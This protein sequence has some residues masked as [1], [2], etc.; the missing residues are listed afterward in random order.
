MQGFRFD[1]P[2]AA[3]EISKR[4]ETSAGAAPSQQPAALA[5]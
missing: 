1:R 4:I 5:S 2:V 3:A